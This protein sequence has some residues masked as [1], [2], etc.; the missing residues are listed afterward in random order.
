[1]DRHGLETDNGNFDGLDA[2]AF[3]ALGSGR[4]G[5]RVVA[6]ARIAAVLHEDL[7]SGEDEGVS[8][9]ERLMLLEGAGIVDEAA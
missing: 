3:F 4:V 5:A 6:A 2:D 7:A 1:M 9:L 8:V